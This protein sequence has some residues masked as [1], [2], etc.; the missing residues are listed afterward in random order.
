ME[1]FDWNQIGNSKKIASGSIQLDDLPLYEKAVKEI[2][3]KN[4]LSKSSAPGGKLILH[5]VFRPS[6]VGR[7]RQNS[8][9]VDGAARALTGIGTGVGSAVT[10]GGSFVGN[11]ANS[12]V[13][14]AGNVVGSGFGLLKKK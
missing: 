6:L 12:I 11:K 13:T 9:V 8:G 7:K 3:L 2:Q 1:V 5:I 10:S 4:E 14:G